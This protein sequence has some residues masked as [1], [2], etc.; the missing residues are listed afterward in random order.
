MKSI[1]AKTNFSINGYVYEAGDEVECKDINIIVKLNE[2]GYI[3][4]LS[5]KDIQNIKRE[6]NKPQKYKNNEEE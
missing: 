6:I 3:Q 1:K 5:A 2:K 4:P